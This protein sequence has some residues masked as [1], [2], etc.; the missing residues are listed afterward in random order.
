[1]TQSKQF[2]LVIEAILTG[3]PIFV[4]NTGIKVSIIKLEKVNR[5]RYYKMKTAT[6]DI[7]FE[8]TPTYKAL[9]TCE[10]YSLRDEMV[11]L[12]GTKKLNI[13]ASIKIMNLSHRPFETK[14]SKA[15]YDPKKS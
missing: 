1:M 14:S 15:L 7:N 10:N 2:K 13:R 5:N 4:K 12:G 9:S 8:Q 6:C 11:T 3:K